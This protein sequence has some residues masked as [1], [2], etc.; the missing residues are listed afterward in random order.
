MSNVAL[1]IRQSQMDALQRDSD[2]R[3]CE[4]ELCA[5]YPDFAGLAGA[6]RY[7]LVSAG[8]K[9]AI[10]FRLTRLEYLTFLCFEQTF[11]PDCLEEPEFTW[12][13]QVLIDSKRGPAER[14]KRLR[15]KTVKRL[16][17]LEA[18]QEREEQAA[19]DAASEGEEES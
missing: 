3:F 13:R 11:Y 10:A 6:E 17:E 2:E 4:R 8:I 7:Q 18:K 16:L 1:N 14:M 15:Q 19:R 5:L 9:R 12:A